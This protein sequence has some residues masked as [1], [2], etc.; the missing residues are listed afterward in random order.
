MILNREDSL[1]P[2]KELPQ[3]LTPGLAQEL[4]DSED[5]NS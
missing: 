2:L 1:M 4:K 3:K 5:Q